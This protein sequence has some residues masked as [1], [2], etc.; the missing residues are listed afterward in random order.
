MNL[1]YQKQVLVLGMCV[2]ST[3]YYIAKLN[4]L[5]HLKKQTL[6]IPYVHN[7]RIKWFLN[8]VLLEISVVAMYFFVITVLF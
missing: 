2:Y 7:F 6:G 1:S 4:K 3:T 5:E 8:F